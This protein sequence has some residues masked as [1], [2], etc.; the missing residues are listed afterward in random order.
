MENHYIKIAEQKLKGIM[1]HTEMTYLF[2]FLKMDGFK[3]LHQ[4]Q[5]EEEAHELKDLMNYYIKNHH[6]LLKVNG[7]EKIQVIPE[8]WYGHKNTEL[9]AATVK[10]AVS[11]AFQQYLSWEEEVKQQLEECANFFYEQESMEDL[12]EVR[13]LIKDVRQEIGC[14]QDIIF[15]LKM[16][17]Y[18]INYMEKYQ[19]KVKDMIECDHK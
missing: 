15:N 4:C 6:K 18:D 7:G 13:K 3:C 17:D 9:D 14:V 12:H 5:A 1:F 19:K 10:N 16:H 11:K 8:G 2:A